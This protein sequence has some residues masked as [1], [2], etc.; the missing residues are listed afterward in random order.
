MPEQLGHGGLD[1]PALLT[2]AVALLAVSGYLCAVSRDAAR[3]HWP[4]SRTWCWLGGWSAVLVGSAGPLAAAA[5]TDFRAH[6]GA[7]VLVGMLGP[8]LLCLGAPASLALRALPVPAGRRVSAL[9]RRR[10]LR[11]L[12]EPSV[13]ALLNVGG[14]WLLYTTPL[15]GL[16]QHHAGV[17]LLVHLHLVLAGY[18]LAAVLVGR[19]PLP[20]R[21]SHLHRAVVLVA[22]LAAH[23]ILA[24][25]L[26]A[27]PPAG[28]D[29]ATARAGAMLMYYGGD[30]VE[31]VLAGLLCRSWFRRAS[32]RPARVRLRTG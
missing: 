15:L 16:A 18:L 8:L 1:L 24:K 4:R 20:H 11:V 17:H 31:L 5:H 28:I 23:G 14:L 29:P 12:T 2:V 9:L 25:L 27:S 22:G 6:A 26:Y 30:A 7:H 10:P 21:R 32:G 3:R 19:D 13:A